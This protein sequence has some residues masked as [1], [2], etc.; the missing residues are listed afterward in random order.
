MMTLESGHAALSVL[1]RLI[2]SY[3]WDESASGHVCELDSRDG[4]IAAVRVCDT[5]TLP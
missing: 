1:I 3:R 2:V 4:L 5:V